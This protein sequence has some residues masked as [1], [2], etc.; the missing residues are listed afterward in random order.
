ML[1]H[2]AHVI[3]LFPIVVKILY[4]KSILL[5]GTFLFFMGIIV[6]D[7]NFYT[8]ILHKLLVLFASVTG[9][10]HYYG[11]LPMISLSIFL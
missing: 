11:R 1:F 4:G 8:S 6:L 7:K 5:L 3:I 10:K 2:R 9:I